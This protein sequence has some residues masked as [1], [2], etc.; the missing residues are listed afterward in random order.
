MP[1]TLSPSCPLRSRI[2]RHA[3][4]ILLVGLVTLSPAWAGVD[5]NTA[6]ETQ[7]RTVKGIGPTKA[8]AILAYRAKNGRFQSVGD[9]RNVKGF[10]AKTYA[11]VAPKLSV[12]ERS[13]PAAA[14]PVAVGARG[15]R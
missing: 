8:R 14:S 1:A 6:N 13:A 12:S 7:L 4:A 15:R 2:F 10:G 3:L 9:L 11:R 5:L